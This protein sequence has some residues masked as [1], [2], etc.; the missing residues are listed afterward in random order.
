MKTSEC[1]DANEWGGWNVFIAPNHFLVVGKVCWRWAHWTVRW[2]TEQSL[3]TVRCAPRQR[4]CWGLEL[5]TVGTLCLFAAPDSPVA[6]RIVRWPLTSALWLLRGTVCHYRLLQSTVGAQG[7]IAPLDHRTVR[8]TP[9]SLVN[10]SGARPRNSREWHVRL[11]AGL[12]HRPVSGANRTLFGVPFFRHSQDL[13]QINLSRQ[14]GFF[15]GLCWTL[16]TWD[17][18]HLDKLVSPRGLCWTS[19]TKIGYRKWLS[20]F[21]F[22]QFVT[23]CRGCT[24]Y[25]WAVIPFLI[26][27]RYSPLTTT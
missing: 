1:F 8:C 15:L 18:W 9:D 27:E 16:C 20:P 22:H 10:Y 6:H 25:P 24:L 7:V 19:T 23:L 5:L 13:L 2:R 17:T 4:T 12:V 14:L 3:F 21:P 26:E 11:L